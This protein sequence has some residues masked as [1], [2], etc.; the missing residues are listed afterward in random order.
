MAK[1]T[2]FTN[3]AGQYT[4]DSIDEARFL[5]NSIEAPEWDRPRV[6]EWTAGCA[7]C[8]CGGQIH[9]QSREVA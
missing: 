7:D 6:F 4:V 9:R 2:V 3:T 5:A 1:Y 8:T